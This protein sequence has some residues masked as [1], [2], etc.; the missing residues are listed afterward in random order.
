ME[1]Y[2]EHT[3]IV[4]CVDHFNPLGLI[5]SLGEDGIKPAVIIYGKEKPYLITKS[6]YPGKTY[7]VKTMED[8]LK[9][10]LEEYSNE[11]FKPFI[12]TCSDD[13]ESFLDLHYDAL[14]D[15]FYFFNGGRQGQ[16]THWMEKTRMARLAE[17][18]GMTIP[19]AEEVA[20]GE[21]PKTLRYPI[22]TKSVISTLYNWKGNVHICHDEKEL[23][24]AY[25]TIRGDRVVLQ[26]YIEKDNEIS[27]E[28]ISINNGKEIYMPFQSRYLRFTSDSFGNYVGFDEPDNKD[29]LYKIKLLFD[30]VSYSGIFSID[31]LHGKDGRIY[32]LEINFRN[33]AWSYACT[34]QGANLPII[35]A[36]SVLT[37][38]LDIADVKLKKT[39]FT[40]MDECADF[41]QA[42][43]V[44][45]ESPVKWYREMK[46][47]D[48]LFYSH[49]NDMQP[50]YAFIGH[51]I[52]GVIKSILHI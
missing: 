27:F 3:F 52:K 26:E 2:K 10:L 17:G 8:G 29:L 18:C 36:R 35:Y 19:K 46:S 13:I 5:R 14:I 12:Y 6:I 30:K 20:V 44:N 50:L 33:S 25:K 7:W 47:C 40:A 34:S 45:R 38:H 43:L 15:R 4:F 49:K 37:G 32:F 48:T 1:S 21:L 39:S 16:V 41:K 22:M 28:G 31:F 9:I 42:V 24:E 11:K 51:R 23:L